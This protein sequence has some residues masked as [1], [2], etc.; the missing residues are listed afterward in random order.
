MLKF[1][2]FLDRDGTLL[3]DVPYNVDPSRMRLAPGATRA[4]PVLAQLGAALFVISNQSGVALGKFAIEALGPV[5]TRLRELCKS[6]G[7]TLDGV[8]WCPHHPGGI[9]KRYG[10]ACACRKPK[11]GMLRRAAREHGLDLR[12]SWFV[13]DILDD[14]EAGCR[15]GCRTILLDNGH[16]TLW[17]DGPYRQPHAIVTDL[18]EAALYIAG[19]PA[20]STQQRGPRADRAAADRTG[21]AR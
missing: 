11:P 20:A 17:Q 13:G 18:H 21:G 5:E 14:V 15:A 1:A 10:R 16:E 4:L 19:A 12:A 8:Y 3:E 2:I 9:V 7:A 6:H